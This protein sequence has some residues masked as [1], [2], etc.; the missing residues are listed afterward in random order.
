MNDPE[1]CTQMIRLRDNSSPSQRMSAADTHNNNT[2]TSKMRSEA[3]G[4]GR[5]AFY[6]YMLIDNGLH[7]RKH[8]DSIVAPPKRQSHL[9]GHLG[10]QHTWDSSVK[11]HDCDARKQR[12]RRLRETFGRRT[13]HLVVSWAPG[14]S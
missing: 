5:M 1:T 6:A 3:V 7:L 2:T 10:A 13:M 8:V 11:E 14:S 12:H 4:A 9:P